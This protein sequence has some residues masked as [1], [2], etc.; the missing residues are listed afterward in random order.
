MGSQRVGHDWVNKHIIIIGLPE[1]N[2]VFGYAK[3]LSWKVGINILMLIEIKF[4]LIKYI[5]LKML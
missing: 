2:K 4:P 1:Q 3:W 5:S